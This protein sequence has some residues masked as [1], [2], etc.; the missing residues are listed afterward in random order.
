ML[1]PA[2]PVAALLSGFTI[3]ADSVK[4]RPTSN[5]RMRWKV[6][7]LNALDDRSYRIY[8]SERAYGRSVSG[9]NDATWRYG[10]RY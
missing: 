4:R 1:R 7:V 2:A 6:D 10:R 9:F 3:V 8:P 5:V